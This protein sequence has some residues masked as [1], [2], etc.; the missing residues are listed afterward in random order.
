M[1]CAG[2]TFAEEE[3]GWCNAP[4]AGGQPNTSQ[5]ESSSLITIK[6]DMELLLTMF[7]VMVFL[8]HKATNGWRI[9]TSESLTANG[10][11]KLRDDD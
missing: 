11:E 8:P 5:D 1:K 2:N 10:E 3:G 7:Y 9:G 6:K 4:T